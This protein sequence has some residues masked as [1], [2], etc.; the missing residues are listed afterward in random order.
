MF[1]IC[2]LFGIIKY[3]QSNIWWD[4]QKYMLCHLTYTI[5]L[6]FQEISH[7]QRELQGMLYKVFGLQKLDTNIMC[8]AGVLEQWLGCLT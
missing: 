3:R 8:Y 7:E 6:F 2:Y 1:L 4:Q 5:P